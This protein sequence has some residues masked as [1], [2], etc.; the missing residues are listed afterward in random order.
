MDQEDCFQIDGESKCRCGSQTVCRFYAEIRNVCSSDL[1]IATKFGVESS[2]VAALIA[3]AGVAIGLAVQ[4]SLSNFAGGILILILKPFEVGDYIMV[5]SAGIE[6]TVKSIQIFYTRMTTIDNKTIIVPNGILTDNSLTNVTA[7]PERQLDL[8]VGIA[9]DADLKKAKGLIE[10]MLLND[11]D[12]IQ[13]E[14]IKVFVDELADSSVVIGL[15]AWVKTE[16]YWTTRWR[17]LEE[18]KLQ[19]DEAGIEI[20]FNQLTVHMKEGK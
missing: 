12:V 20:P 10:T 4:G 16:A 11:K 2:S 9:Y 19:F 18:I 13:D 8:K 6:G 5:N 17:V 3:S 1:L 7:R 15:R 14:E